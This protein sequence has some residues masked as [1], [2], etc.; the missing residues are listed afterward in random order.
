M[1]IESK[2]DLLWYFAYGSNMSVAKFSG[3]RGIIPLNA[4]PVFIPGWVLLMEIPGLPYSEPSFSSIRRRMQ[5]DLEVLHTP[6]VSGVA[7]LITAKQYQHVVA[8]EGGGIA[9]CD[10]E[11]VGTR[12]D[13]GSSVRLRTLG[14]AMN[15][16]P[17]PRPSER[18]MG[19]LQQGAKDA[20]LSMEYCQYLEDLPTYQPSSSTWHRLGAIIFL[21]IFRPLMALMEEI[22]TTN[23]KEDGNAPRWVI[24]IVRFTV[25]VIWATHDWIF[26]PVFGRGDGLNSFD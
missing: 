16:S 15:R 21:N 24:A 11:A 26:T 18:Y 13:D 4:T 2:D 1:D 12:I 14:S 7:Y 6:D 22:T 19:L 20:K 10:I 17:C 3:S 9:Y 25:F 8:S 23:I 5:D